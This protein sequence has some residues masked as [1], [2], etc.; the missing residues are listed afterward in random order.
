MIIQTE[1]QETATKTY[2]CCYCGSHDLRLARMEN[3]HDINL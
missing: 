2:N 3:V 1:D